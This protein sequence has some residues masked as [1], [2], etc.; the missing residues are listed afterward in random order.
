MSLYSNHCGWGQRTTH[1]MFHSSQ[2]QCAR[3]SPV[4]HCNYIV[5]ISFRFRAGIQSL[6]C[7]LQSI[8]FYKI[9]IPLIVHP[10]F[11]FF[12]QIAVFSVSVF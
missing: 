7:K 10:L 5:I 11:D 6:L 9:L 1:L 8:P 12:F 4:N 2:E 3:K